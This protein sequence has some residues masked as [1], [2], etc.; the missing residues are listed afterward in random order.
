MTLSLIS[1]RLI[2]SNVSRLIGETPEFTWIVLLRMVSA[3]IKSMGVKK[4]KKVQISAKNLSGFGFFLPPPSG[5]SRQTMRP[6]SSLWQMGRPPK[7]FQTHTSA[8]HDNNS[9]DN[10]Q[11][12][13]SFN[14]PDTKLLFVFLSCWSVEATGV[15]DCTLKNHQNNSGFDFWLLLL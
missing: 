1:P 4:K 8:R 13:A 6:F 15:R 12:A 5:W 2:K 7:C 9:S 10:R 14:Q 11:A 3:L